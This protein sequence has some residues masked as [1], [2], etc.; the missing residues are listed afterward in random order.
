MRLTVGPREE[1]RANLCFFFFFFLAH[2]AGEMENIL[3]DL[4]ALETSYSQGPAHIGLSQ[5]FVECC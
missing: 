3:A 4:K 5:T 2:T 1:M